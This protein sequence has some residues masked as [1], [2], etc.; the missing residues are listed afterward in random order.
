[1]KERAC[2][3]ARALFFASSSREPFHLWWPFR[4]VGNRRAWSLAATIR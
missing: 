2:R 1:M 3:E 4:I